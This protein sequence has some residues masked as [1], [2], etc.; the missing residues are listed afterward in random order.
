M[1]TK[2]SKCHYMGTQLAESLGRDL[3]EGMKEDSKLRE[4]FT[5]KEDND[6]SNSGDLYTVQLANAIYYKSY[7]DFSKY[8]DLVVNLTPKDLG[9]P[10]GAGSYKIPKI[11]ACTAT[12]VSG[13]EV[14]DYVNDN[15]DSITLETETFAVGTRI[16]RRLVKR[17]AKGF[18]NVLMKSASDAVNRAISSEIINDIV[19]GAATANT[20]TGGV[21]YDA[22]QDAKY[23]VKNAK[24]SNSIIFGF[25]PNMIAFS[26]VG[27]NTFAKSSDFKS[28]N[29]Y[30]STVV[31]GQKVNNEY[32]MWNG[33]KIMEAELLDTTKGGATVHAVVLDTNY[34]AV[35]LQEDSMDTY[36]G[37][38][39]GTPGDK[40]IIFASDAGVV[41]NNSEA[42]A[43]ITA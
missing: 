23:N 11:M 29:N 24:D 5:F 16:N 7:N 31:P 40:E 14:V 25:T 43:V 15:K 12:K 22:V 21:D 38:L 17:G 33:L 28:I 32:V 27:W 36:D 2:A 18:I 37:R 42:I 34:G 20:V 4:A 41:V 9:M 26:N 35:F 13:G 8:R 6:M 10:D 19:A 3:V 1:L 30:A 39:P